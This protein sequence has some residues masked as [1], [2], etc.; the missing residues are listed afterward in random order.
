MLLSYIWCLFLYLHV[1]CTMYP[2]TV[3]ECMARNVG[4]WV[5]ANFRCGP[6]NQCSM[7]R[8]KKKLP[9]P[10]YLGLL[11]VRKIF[12]GSLSHFLHP[13]FSLLLTLSLLSLLLLCWKHFEEK[14]KTYQINN[15]NHPDLLEVLSF[16]LAT[17]LSTVLY[18][19]TLS[20]AP[21]YSAFFSNFLVVKRF[22]TILGLDSPIILIHVL[23]QVVGF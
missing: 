17:F 15:P 18:F 11:L 8:E 6:S 9:I 20:C 13:L 22:P 1:Q 23:Y 3:C 12:E 14:K 7:T 5:L 16:L 4:Q 21:Q 2:W 10:F 19:W